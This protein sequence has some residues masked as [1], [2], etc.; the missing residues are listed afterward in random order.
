MNENEKAALRADVSAFLNPQPAAEVLPLPA[1]ANRAA[2]TP[3]QI[4]T[5]F[6]SWIEFIYA[7]PSQTWQPDEVA[8]IKVAAQ[9]ALRTL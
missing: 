9:R 2:M 6:E 1:L 7:R 3:A 4:E 5:A 8:A